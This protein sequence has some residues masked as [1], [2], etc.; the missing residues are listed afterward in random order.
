[1][2]DLYRIFIY[3]RFDKKRGKNVDGCEQLRIGFSARLYVD[4]N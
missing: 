2:E 4:L 1:M 3:A